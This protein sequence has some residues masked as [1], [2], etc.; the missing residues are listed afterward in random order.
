[1]LMEKDPVLHVCIGIIFGVALSVVERYTGVNAWLSL[2]ITLP[3]ISVIY[4]WPNIT[5]WRKQ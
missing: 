5:T 3:I 4:L 1:M 2:V